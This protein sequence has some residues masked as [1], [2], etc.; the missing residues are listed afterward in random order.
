M[1]SHRVGHDW[2][3]E[4]NW[5]HLKAKCRSR[6]ICRV[7]RFSK[8]VFNFDR[9]APACALQLS[10]IYEAWC[11]CKLEGPFH[12]DRHRS[13][14][15]PAPPELTAPAYGTLLQKRLLL[16]SS[17]ASQQGEQPPGRGFLRLLEP[18]RKGSP[19]RH[20]T[21][22][23]PLWSRV[24]RA[25]RPIT[26]QRRTL[27]TSREATLGGVCLSLRLGTLTSAVRGERVC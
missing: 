27:H 22:M 20:R 17:P 13:R 6:R 16:D 26:T 19:A 4:L 2:A 24:R 18:G 7:G 3:A 10:I 15:S 21:G 5:V 8:N 12:T 25:L 1:G 23:H 11:T 9:L 14:G